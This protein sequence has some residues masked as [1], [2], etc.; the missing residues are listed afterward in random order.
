[1][2]EMKTKTFKGMLM[3][4]FCAGVQSNPAIPSTPG[5]ETESAES[6]VHVGSKAIK[7]K[8]SGVENGGKLVVSSVH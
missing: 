2:K 6:A 3:N 4:A 1:M 7:A 8:V 5:F